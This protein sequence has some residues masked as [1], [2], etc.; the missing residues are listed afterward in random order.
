ALYCVSCSDSVSP[1]HCH[2][3]KKCSEGEV[4]FKESHASENGLTVFDTG[5]ASPQSCQ[6]HPEA[7]VRTLHGVDPNNHQCMKCCSSHLCNN[8]GCGQPGYPLSRGPVCFNCPQVS[9]PMLCDKLKVCELNQACVSSLSS[10]DIIGKR[11]IEKC[12]KCCQEDLCNN[13]YFD[14][15]SSMSSTTTTLKTTTPADSTMRPTNSMSTT[16]QTYT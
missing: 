3:V 6:L 12:S 14:M 5:C 4:C 7:D 8:Q 11:N 10:V 9:D 16:Q 2:T 13:Q 1:R 15:F